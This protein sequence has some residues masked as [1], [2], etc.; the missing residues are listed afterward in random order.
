MATGVLLINLGTPDSTAVGDV[1]KYLRQ[2]L[3]D[4]RVLDLPALGRWALLNLIILPFRPKQS[5]HAYKQIW[6]E[7]GSPLLIHTRNLAAAV[8]PVLGDG[9][10][11]QFA[12]RYQNPPIRRALDHFNSKGITQIVVVP[13]YPQYASSSTGSVLEE[14]YR[15]ASSYWN[16]PSLTVIEPFYHHPEFKSCQAEV[17]GE[18]LG[19]LGQYDHFLLSFHGLP[20]RHVIKCD[21]TGNHC[22]QNPDCCDTITP[23]NSYCYRAQSF[24]SAADLAA[25]LG[26]P[27]DKYSVGFQ[28]R[29][30]RTPW[31]KPYTDDVFVELAQKGVR[32]LAVVVP[33]FTADCLETLEE[34]AIRGKEDFIA[35]GGEDLVMAPCLNAHPA[36]ARVIADMVT[37]QLPER[38]RKTAT[39]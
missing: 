38:A 27:D 4:P 39:V 17:T 33:S 15:I 20:E 26:I 5:A 36:F 22:L 11:V 29:L 28:S 6:T 37:E 9:F 18:Y 23:V 1:R 7:E 12:M 16:V 8:A 35:A 32:K 31:I 2:F 3:S 25:R 19:D 34:I 10:D 30:G 13:L 14:I 24:A 21:T